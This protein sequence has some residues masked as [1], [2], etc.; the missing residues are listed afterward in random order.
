MT[1]DPH[2]AG[3][4]NWV[5]MPRPT[6]AP[7]ALAAGITLMALGV[8]TSLAFVPVGALI[9]I[10]ALGRWIDQLLPGRG[11]QREPFVEP[12]HA[13]TADRACPGRR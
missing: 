5:E 8:A 2:S 12:T 3:H 10:V 6:A 13:S 4:D 7:I 1:H 11:H 9:F